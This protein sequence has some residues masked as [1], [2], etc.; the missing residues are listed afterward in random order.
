MISD[1]RGMTGERQE[2]TPLV[3][4]IVIRVEAPTASI[5][6]FVAQYCRYFGSEIMFLP[7]EGFQP[8]GRR[9][10]FAFALSDGREIVWGEGVVMRMRRDSGNPSRPPGMEL[11]YFVLDEESQ[12]IVDRML[13]LRVSGAQMG[14]PEPPPY[15]SMWLEH[16]SADDDRTTR[17]R[18]QSIHHTAEELQEQLKPI[19]EKSPT[20]PANPF[21]DVT[22]E[23]LEYFVEWA[24]SRMTGAPRRR[25]VTA[26]IA[27]L[28]A[29]PPARALLSFAAGVAMTVAA[30]GVVKL[31][32]E[33]HP[34]HPPASEAQTARP[35]ERALPNVTALAKADARPR[36]V[37]PPQVPS[38]PTLIGGA[39]TP[40]RSLPLPAPRPAAQLATPSMPR[41][42]LVHETHET[43]E[44]HEPSHLRHPGK[45]VVLSL[46]AT[47]ADA[48]LKLDGES[49]THGP[50]KLEV[51]AGTHE[52]LVERPRYASARLHVEAPGHLAV[53]LSR[54]PATLRVTSTPPGANVTL[55]GQPVGVTPLELTVTAYEQHHVDLELGGQSR[56][57]RVYVRPPFAAVEVDLNQSGQRDKRNARYRQES[58]HPAS[59]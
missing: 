37:S 28:S 30:I 57:R 41:P 51:A 55:D 32:T 59:L 31:V 10:R 19:A 38:E 34:P 26:E 47:P 33:R 50:L 1:G 56:R 43:H 35:R 22:R 25:R 7:T 29:K 17:P 12:A 6:E 44:L 24:M 27:I 18:T 14:K 16:S 45:M 3:P 21:A 49:P 2:N 53:H 46:R 5:D 58:G 23:A 13:Q 15:V 54:P 52:L 20:L 48:L 9:V 4:L 39:R 11:R 40:A 42:S 8:A 36:V